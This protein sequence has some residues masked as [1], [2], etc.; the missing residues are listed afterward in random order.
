M[1]KE[2]G[3]SAFQ[4][5]PQRRN[6]RTPYKETF[7]IAVSS[8]PRSETLLAISTNISEGG[9]CIYTFRPLKEGQDILFKKALP[10]PHH[11]GTVRWVKQ[12]KPSIYMAG[13]LLS[14]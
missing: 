3:T 14:S 11:K 8:N 2:G 12:I 13:V 1:N 10:V 6:P 4:Y 9:I 5:S 7:E